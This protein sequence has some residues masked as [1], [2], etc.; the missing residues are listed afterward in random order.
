MRLRWRRC[1]PL[2]RSFPGRSKGAYAATGSPTARMLSLLGTITFCLGVMAVPSVRPGFLGS[3]SAFTSVRPPDAIS[4][5]W[6]TERWIRKGRSGPARGSRTPIWAAQLRR[7]GAPPCRVRGRGPVV[8]PHLRV[9]HALGLFSVGYA[10][11]WGQAALGVCEVIDRAARLGYDG[12]MIAGKRPHLSPLDAAPDT[13]EPS[14]TA[15]PG[16]GC[17]TRSSPPTPTSPAARPARCPT[18][19]CRSPTSRQRLARLAAQYALAASCGSSR[20]HESPGQTR[21]GSVAAASS[22]PSVSAAIALE[23]TASRSLSRT[24]TISPFTRQHCWS[25]SPTSTGPTASS[26]STPGRRRCAAR[27]CT[28]RARRAAAHGH[29]H[30][31]RLRS[32]CRASSISRAR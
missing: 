21:R 28:S 32:A 22:P 14:R 25:C 13:I 29:H 5:K 16:P 8:L 20:P 4:G 7:P 11:F 2:M 31:R 27:I 3:A 15:W 23:P 6:T 18:P 24:T 12:V 30:Q 10:G 9:S 26:A 17:G 19:R 1:A